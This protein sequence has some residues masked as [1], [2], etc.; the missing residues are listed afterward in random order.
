MI[1]FDYYNSYRRKS[2][3]SGVENSLGSAIINLQLA[4]INPLGKVG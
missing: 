4:W 3:T 2:I 1:D